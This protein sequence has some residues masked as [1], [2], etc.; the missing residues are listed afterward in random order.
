RG[1]FARNRI[2]IVDPARPA[3]VQA[4]PLDPHIDYARTPGPRA[5]IEKSLAQPC[6]IAWDST[7]RH[8]YLAALG[9]G[10]VAEV[11]RAGAVVRR[12]AVGPGPSGVAVDD[13][14]RRLYVVNRFDNTL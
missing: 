11:N 2:T 3:A 13:R 9:S 10:R 14:R 6:D 12:I 4:V 1:R 7:G 8:G 5:E